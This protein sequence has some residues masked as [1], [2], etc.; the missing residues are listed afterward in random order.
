MN[1][2]AL[3]PCAAASTLRL[4]DM[5]VDKTNFVVLCPHPLLTPAGSEHVGLAVRTIAPSPPPPA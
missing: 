3:S 5:L 2:F 4:D 1:D